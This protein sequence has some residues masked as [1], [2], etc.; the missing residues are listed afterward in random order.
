MRGRGVSWATLVT[1]SR[2]LPVSTAS[3]SAVWE[4]KKLTPEQFSLFQQFIYRQTGIRM[5]DG[6]I[7]LLSN[8]IRRRLRDLGLDSFE[9][10]YRLLVAKK[11]PGELEPFIDAVTTNETHFFRTGGHFEW[12]GGP[13]LDDITGRAAAGLHD[14]SLRVWSAACSSG[15]EAY[16]L[17][18]CLV[19]SRQRLPGWRLS[20]LGTDISETVIAQARAGKYR[21]R[22]LEQVSPE[23]LQ[24]HFV[25]V[26]EETWMVKP[27]VAALCEFQ[28]HNLLQPL[29]ESG[30]DCIFIRNV[31]IYF[32]RASKVTAVRNLVA[33]LAPGGYLV[34]GPADGIYDM[35]GDLRRHSSFLY[36][37]P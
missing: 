19:E 29:G 18:I 22:S 24:Q 27:A 10:Y 6:K 11:L 31:L 16:S 15:E 2:E 21:Q 1:F 8:R 5:Q 3:E 28:R 33:S 23:R 34:V 7:T 17:A 12:F 32:D 25:A 36:Q 35:L 20:V 14:R 30:F 26:E 4:L 9:E 13:F 37:K